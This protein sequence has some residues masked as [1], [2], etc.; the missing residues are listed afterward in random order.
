VGPLVD[1]YRTVYPCGFQATWLQIKELV[2]NE[3][4]V[5]YA[6]TKHLTT[7]L[8]PPFPHTTISWKNS[9]DPVIIISLDEDEI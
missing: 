3:P 9:N 2:D 6:P 4:D 7:L 5:E 1:A 8:V